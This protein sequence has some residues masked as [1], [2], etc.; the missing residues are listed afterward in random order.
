MRPSLRLSL[1]ISAVV[2]TLALSAA[3]SAQ[4]L[5]GT[6]TNGT[7]NKPAAGDDVILIKLA[8]GMEEAART[9]T[10]SKGAFHFD[11]SDAGGPH[12]IR[13]IHQN[14]TYHHMAPPGTSSVD[15]Q[16][17]DVAKKIEGISATADLLYVQA[18]RTNS[19]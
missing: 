8:Q 4:T 17:F 16:V 6:V 15:V 5:T 11:L 10:D 2:L 12:L 14:V 18:N 19:G 9:K 1:R 13:V 3:A 7:T